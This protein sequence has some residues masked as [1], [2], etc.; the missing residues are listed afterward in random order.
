MFLLRFLI[1]FLMM[2]ATAYAA[3]PS[4]SLSPTS[5]SISYNLIRNGTPIGVI[6][7]TLEIK[8]GAYRATSEAIA[9]G[10]FALAQ[11]HPIAYLSSG[12]VTREGLRPLRFE[13]RRNNTLATAD[14]DWKA[15][16]LLLAH[17]GLNQ[18]LP[19]P[20]ATQDRLSS[21]YH[22]MHLMQSKPRSV[23]F[24]MT[25]GRKLDK[26]RYEVVPDVAVDT[27]LRRYNTLHLVKQREAGDTQAEVWLAPELHYLPV[28]VFVVENDNVRY[29]QVV[30]RVEVKP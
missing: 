29:E 9:T 19:L 6:H 30:T 23:E 10:L 14:F 17:D 18:A 22:F 27:P 25:N 21:M 12:E 8:D 24:A 16:K 4:S 26:Y 1:S 20:P 3:S 5:V 13:G 15:G 11:R 2:A 28:K 7:E